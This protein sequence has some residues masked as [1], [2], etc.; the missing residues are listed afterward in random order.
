MDQKAVALQLRTLA[1]DPENQAYIVNE[2]SCMKGLMSFMDST[3]SAVLLISLQ[4][5]NF[6]SSHPKNQEQLSK[7][8]GLLSKLAQHSD[9]E[10]ADVAKLSGTILEHLTRV[11]NRVPE[12]KER[13]TYRPKYLQSIHLNVEGL[14]KVSRPPRLTRHEPLS[15]TRGCFAQDAVPAVERSLLDVKGIV[16]VTVER[17][18]TRITAYTRKEDTDMVDQLIA[19][20][21]GHSVKV[22]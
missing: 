9:H 15:E 10:N 13:P 19:A 3:D 1:A 12:E 4:A 8:P 18:L 17:S 20:L 21:A 14:V 6:L 7:E 16:S 11:V 22:N 5:L 2:R